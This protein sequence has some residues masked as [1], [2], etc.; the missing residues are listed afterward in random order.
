MPDRSTVFATDRVGPGARAAR[1]V[2]CLCIGAHRT[3]RD[4]LAAQMKIA[5]VHFPGRLSRLDAARAGT[6]PKSGGGPTDHHGAT[7]GDQTAPCP[8]TLC[9]AVT[10]PRRSTLDTI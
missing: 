9:H 7:A 6:A 10:D 5:F 3:A 1:R 4:S 8:L 2:R